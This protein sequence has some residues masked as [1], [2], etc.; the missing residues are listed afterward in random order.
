MWLEDGTQKWLPVSGAVV[1]KKP[2]S[3]KAG[4]KTLSVVQES[5]I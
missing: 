4:L 3:V 1:K 5:S 2:M